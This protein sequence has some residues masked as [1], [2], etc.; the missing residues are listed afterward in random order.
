MTALLILVL[1]LTLL[2]ACA[3][4]GASRSPVARH[5]NGRAV[6]TDVPPQIIAGATVLPLRAVA[7][8]LGADVDGLPETK[9]AY[10]CL[11]Q[12][13]CSVSIADRTSGARIIKGRVMVPVRKTAELLGC[14][15]S[16]DA[17]ARVVRIT[18]PKAQTLRR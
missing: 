9:T 11:D 8:A 12:R 16:W 2:P 4:A 7:E 13:C 14:Q 3:L 17:T 15:V 10:L 6:S 5:V 18:T 1:A